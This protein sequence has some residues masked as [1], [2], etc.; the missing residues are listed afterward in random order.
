M[1]KSGNYFEFFHNT[2][3]VKSTIPHFQVCGFYVS[4]GFSVIH[5]RM[6]VVEIMFLI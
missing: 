1:E 4:C 6:I 2:R 5:I 3:L